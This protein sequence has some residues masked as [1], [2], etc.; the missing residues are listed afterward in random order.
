MLRTSLAA[1][2]AVFLLACGAT[3]SST[4]LAVEASLPADCEPALPPKAS[5]L[6]DDFEDGD[7]LLD[8]SLNLHGRWYAENDGTGTQ[9]AGPLVRAPGAAESPEHALYLGG[10]GFQSWGAFVAT[11][12]NASQ[13]KAC[14]Y[15]LSRQAGLSFL[16]KGHG[17]MR[18]NWGTVTTTPV[19]DGGEC[20]EDLCSD[21]GQS[22]ELEQ[23][24]RAVKVSFSDLAQ[25]SWAAPA[26]WEPARV[27]RLSFWGEEAEFE[28]W[29]DELRLY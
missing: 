27:L 15:D 22:V 4:S 1:G 18:V 9:T 11:R 20:A 17:R 19:V 21:Y 26:S 16:A 23:D 2:T 29:L 5:L 24:W 25:P 13:S 3:N 28:L 6:I 7:R 12:L 14:A 10:S 8:T